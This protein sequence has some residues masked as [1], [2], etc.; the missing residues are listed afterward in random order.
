MDIKLQA[1][2]VKLCCCSQTGDQ[3][4]LQNNQEFT[5]LPAQKG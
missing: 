4:T 2:T 1:H 3:A 5:M